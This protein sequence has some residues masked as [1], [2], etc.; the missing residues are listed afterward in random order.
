[1][2][3]LS[4]IIPFLE[5]M[6]LRSSILPKFYLMEKVAKIPLNVNNLVFVSIELTILIACIELVSQL[7]DSFVKGPIVV[8]PHFHKV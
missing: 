8:L 1:M 5:P 6:S 4:S 2:E 3:E 7:L